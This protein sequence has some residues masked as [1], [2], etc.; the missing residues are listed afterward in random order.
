MIPKHF[1]CA[2]FTIKIEIVDKL[3]SNNYGQFCDATNT[4]KIAKTV[5]IEDEGTVELT[6]EQR[7]NTFFHELVHVFQFYYDNEY[8]EAQAQV[9]ANFLCEY[10][11]TKA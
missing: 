3:K 8:C 2:G 5:E 7:F 1:E 6:E 4:I 9:F 10:E 11:K